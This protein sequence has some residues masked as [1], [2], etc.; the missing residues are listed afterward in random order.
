MRRRRRPDPPRLSPVCPQLTRVQP[1]LRS[2]QL[3]LRPVRRR[4]S[5]VPPRLNP[6]RR[7][8]SKVPPRLSPV[9]PRLSPVRRRLSLATLLG[10]C[11]SPHPPFRDPPR[12]PP[13]SSFPNSVWER[14]SPATRCP[15]RETEFRPRL[16]SQTEFG[17]EENAATN[18][19]SRRTAPWSRPGAPWSGATNSWSGATA[20]TT[21]AVPWYGGR[22][23]VLGSTTKISG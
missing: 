16:H 18:P 21:Q 3:P 19:W 2:V 13:F 5:S 4:R 6:M 11:V 20:P 1:P 14:A 7:P 15:P 23:Y 17:N 22:W 9:S 10:E 8:L 12:S